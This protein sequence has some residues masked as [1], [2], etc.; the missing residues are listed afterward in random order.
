MERRGEGGAPEDLQARK[1]SRPWSGVGQGRVARRK[2]Q[3]QSHVSPSTTQLAA[4]RV[5]CSDD[6]HPLH[7]RG[8]EALWPAGSPAPGEPGSPRS[9]LWAS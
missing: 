1:E 6:A 3:P 5:A 8:S 2:R 4:M 7:E 9:P